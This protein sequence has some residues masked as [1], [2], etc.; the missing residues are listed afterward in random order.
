M[1]QRGAD[2]REKQ[3]ETLHTRQ[4]NLQRELNQKEGIYSVLQREDTHTHTFSLSLSRARTET[5]TR[6]GVSSNTVDYCMSLRVR[7]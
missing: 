3:L 2:E 7:I 5:E 4:H 6:V 1:V